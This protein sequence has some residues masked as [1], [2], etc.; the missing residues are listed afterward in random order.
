MAFGRA[1]LKSNGFLKIAMASKRKLQRSYLPSTNV[2]GKWAQIIG[3]VLL[4]MTVFVTSSQS[5]VNIK[6]GGGIGLMDPASNLSGSTI[7]YY[8][9]TGYGLGSGLN[10][11]GRAK[12]G[13][14]GLNLTGEIDYAS[15]SNSGF[16]Q[17]GQGVV[18]ISQKI[19]TLKVG[20]EFRL[21]IPV[22]PFTP[23]LGVNIASNTFSGQTTFQGVADVPSGDYTVN[24]STRFGVGFSLGTE[25]SLGPLMSLDFNI[26]YNLMNLS[27][28]EWV[29]VN[30]ALNERIDSYLSLN[31]GQDPQYAAGDTKHFVAS[32]RTIQS[33]LLTA[34]ILF[35]L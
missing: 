4:G 25:L 8:N 2:G 31:D 27:G 33:I 20:P 32:D 35:G 18:D 19:L 23:Y 12:I 3:L 13:F 30:P 21:G 14:S 26:A 11:D 6:L 28:K 5:Q 22:L 15:L 16:S 17:P 1:V 34:N 9:G 29:N 24:A 10:I 7:D